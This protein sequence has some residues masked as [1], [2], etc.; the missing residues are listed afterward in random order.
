[1]IKCDVLKRSDVQD[2]FKH[3]RVNNL[4]IKGIIN[5][6]AYTYDE[7][8]SPLSSEEDKVRNV[9][10]VNY[11]GL[12]SVFEELVSDEDFTKDRLRIVNVLSNSIKTLNASNHHYIS[13]KVAAETLTKFYAK[14]CSDNLT[15]NNIAPGLMKS[16]LTEKR[17]A[18]DSKDIIAATPL[19]RLASVDEVAELTLYLATKVPLSL[20]G[21]TL[22]IDGGRTL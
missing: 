16:R 19:G 14:K 2:I 17:F 9:L 1:M 18:K 3:I 6:F 15:I 13:S 12:S 21:Q 7:R 20:C 22:Y 10:N 5:N 8:V 4:S 11:F